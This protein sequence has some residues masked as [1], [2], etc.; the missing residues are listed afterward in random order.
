MNYYLIL[1]ILFVFGIF[2]YLISTNLI[3]T[4]QVQYVYVDRY[5]REPPPPPPQIYRNE[6]VRIGHIE[7]D[8][9]YKPLYGKQLGRDIW[10]YYVMDGTQDTGLFPVSVFF[11][12]RDCLDHNGCRQIYNQDTVTLDNYNKIYQVKMYD[13]ML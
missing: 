9:D 2:N 4:N 5:I 6:F 12:N 11:N 10:K 8:T 13:R 7:H 1:L 3:S